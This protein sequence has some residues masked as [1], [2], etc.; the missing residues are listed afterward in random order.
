MSKVVVSLTSIPERLHDGYGESGVMGCLRSLCEQDYPDYVVRLNLPIEYRLKAIKTEIPDWLADMVARYPRLE[1]KMV[2]D[3]GSLTKIMPALRDFRD[4]DTVLIIVDDDVVY[5]PRMVSEHVRNQTENGGRFAIGY[6]G[7][8]AMERPVYGNVRDHFVVGVD[9]PVSVNMLQHYKSVSY[10]RRF[11]DD[12]I[13][14]FVS[15]TNSDD[16]AISA[17]MRKHGILKMVWPHA[18]DP[19]WDSV[20]A[21]QEGINNTFPVIRHCGHDRNG[22]NDVLHNDV[23]FFEPRYYVENGWF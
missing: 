14:E 23:K 19:R 4:G 17:Y 7:L 20:E 22:C 3:E 8:D 21:W 6:D 12:D 5:D 1:I 15:H 13:W 18:D 11:F 9:R 2:E 10:M 16:V